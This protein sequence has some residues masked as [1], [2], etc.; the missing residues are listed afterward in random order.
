MDN[1]GFDALWQRA[2]AER[3]AS[4]LAAEY[5]VWR[6]NRRRTTGIVSSV[7]LAI[8]VAMPLANHFRPTEHIYCN[9]PAINDSHW[10]EMADALLM[11]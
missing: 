5:P 4:Q 7:V 3:Y 10:T 8:A 1:K 6:A 9:N 11:S 2:E